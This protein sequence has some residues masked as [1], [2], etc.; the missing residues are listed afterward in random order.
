MK[1]QNK[2]ILTVI[3]MLLICLAGYSGYR[4]YAVFHGYRQARQA[5]REFSQEYVVY[6]EGSGSPEVYVFSPSLS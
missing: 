2:K 5:Y 4:T 1:A 3:C 6:N